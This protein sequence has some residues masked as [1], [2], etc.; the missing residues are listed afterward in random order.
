MMMTRGISRERGEGGKPTIITTSRR[1]QP[2]SAAL[3]WPEGP[4]RCNPWWPALRDF[5]P[6]TVACETAVHPSSPSK[7]KDDGIA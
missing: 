4:C 5:F 7:A 3:A 6:T 1:A 2:S